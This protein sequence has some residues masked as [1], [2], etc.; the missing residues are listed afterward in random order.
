MR[1]LFAVVAGLLFAP[2]MY[3]GG[4]RS[5]PLAFPGAEG[6]GKHA[7]G[8]RGG[9]VMEVTNVADAGPGSLRACVEAT[10][11]RTC[12]FRRGGT[13]TLSRPLDVTSGYLTIAGQTA[14][15]QGVQVRLASMVTKSGPTL[16][17]KGADHII[18][19][20]INLRPGMPS[21]GKQQTVDAVTLEGVNHVIFDHTTM[22]WAADEN[23]DIFLAGK[24][25]T[26]QH[27]ILAEGLWPHSKGALFCADPPTYCGRITMYRNYFYLNRDRNPDVNP[28]PGEENVI[29]IVNNWIYDPYSDFTEIWDTHGGAYVNHV[30]NI[31]DKGPLTG[32]GAR[33]IRVQV[34]A[35]PAEPAMRIYT[36]DNLSETIPMS[37]VTGPPYY[38]DAPINGGL[39]VPAGSTI[40]L[41]AEIVANVGPFFWNRDSANRRVVYAGRD[42]TGRNAGV[43][44]PSQVGGWPS[45]S[46]GFT[47]YPDADHDGQSDVWEAQNGLSASNPDD[48]N[49]DLDGDGY[50]N[51]E[52]FLAVLAR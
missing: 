2:I 18:V 13:I 33:C 1:R 35:A 51:L 45:L 10:L 36:A 21:N 40:T 43:T 49:G 14:P 34:P 20:H 29:D 4:L 23:F 3:P 5:E 31:C 11:P 37:N 27:S 19:R 39:S 48:R 8:G 42:Q 7:E 52:E 32:S 9:I 30:A 15:S 38:I 50:T 25:V 44:S 17:V 6:F 41:K 47:P 26:V 16:S 28:L 12:V 22:M 46:T 24:N